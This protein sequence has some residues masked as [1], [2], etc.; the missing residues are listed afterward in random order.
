[1]EEAAKKVL[2]RLENRCARCEYCSG[3]IYTKAVKALSAVPEYKDDTEKVRELAAQLLSS[4]QE[5]GY[6]DDLRYASAFAREKSAISG[7]G[8]VKIRFALTS[9]RIPSRLIEEALSEIDAG[10][11]EEKLRRLLESKWKIL[12]GPDGSIPQDARLKLI[13]FALSRGYDYESVRGPIEEVTRN[14][15]S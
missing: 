5:N 8:P 3:D 6:V 15:Q 4:L 2:L 14:G 1:M 7:W 9:K 11:S 12:T 10:R 13:R